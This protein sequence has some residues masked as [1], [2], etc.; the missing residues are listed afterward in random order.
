MRVQVYN[1]GS[2]TVPD[3]KPDVSNQ[4]TETNATPATPSTENEQVQV[5]PEATTQDTIEISTSAQKLMTQPATIRPEMV[6][7]ARKVL[8]SGTYNDNGAIEAT[9]SKLAELFSS[10]S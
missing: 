8:Q 9:A 6:E 3:K 1:S 4:T 7:R 10:E 5:N 2:P